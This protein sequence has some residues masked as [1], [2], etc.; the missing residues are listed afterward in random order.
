MRITSVSLVQ[1]SLPVYRCYSIT[2]LTHSLSGA[3]VC[4][5]AQT[6]RHVSTVMGACS[7]WTTLTAPRRGKDRQQQRRLTA[8]AGPDLSSKWSSLTGG[9]F[10]CVRNSCHGKITND[11]VAFQA[12][13]LYGVSFQMIV[14]FVHKSYDTSHFLPF[15]LSFNASWSVSVL[16]FLEAE[17]NGS[18]LSSQI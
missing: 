7:M 14:Y 10:T 2:P 12:T 9:V 17:R 16:T 6:G 1:L 18:Y 4:V 3:C 11:E 5:C 8:C 15:I 13:A